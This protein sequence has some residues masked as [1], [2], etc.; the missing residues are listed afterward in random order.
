M[1]AV[2]AEAAVVVEV[3]VM[4]LT[5]CSITNTMTGK[6]TIVFFFSFWFFGLLW[7]GLAL[8]FWGRVVW[9]RGI[10]LVCFLRS[11]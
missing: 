11:S 3:A 5:S 2:A 8:G 6:A 9:W 7:L 1:A 4:P 10:Y